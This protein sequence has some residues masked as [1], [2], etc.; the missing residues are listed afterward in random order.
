VSLIPA[1]TPCA[2]SQIENQDAR[3]RIA[4]RPLPPSVWED[5]DDERLLELRLCDLDLRLEG[6]E[7][8]ART[9]E[10]ERELEQ[11]GLRFRP[12]YWL[13]DEWFCPDGVPGIAI[14]FYLA[15]P[16]LARLELH[17]MLEVEGGVALIGGTNVC[18]GS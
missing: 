8:E 15:H 12:H 6:T 17:Q 9:A 16:R 14:P 13:S 10:L 5:W 3:G 2:A 11:T 18:V 4:R 1:P 7:L